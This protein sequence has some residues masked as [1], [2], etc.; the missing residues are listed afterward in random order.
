M[1]AAATAFATLA[2]LAIL[3]ASPSPHAVVHLPTTPQ[4]DEFVVEVNGKGQVVRIDSG[5]PSHDR[6]F[7][8]ITFGNALQ[9]FIRTTEGNAVA[10]RYRLRYDYDPATR[11][12]RR[13]V[14][15]LQRGG[16]DPAGGP[17]VGRPALSGGERA[18]EAHDALDGIVIDGVGGSAR[19][20]AGLFDALLEGRLGGVH[21]AGVDV[22][23]LR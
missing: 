10:G 6:A 4:H 8:S 18:E 12:I 2:T 21:D 11:R 23:E 22:A 20:L 7:D 17:V 3:G 19:D 13:N 16:V 14:A 5:T 15:I 9:V 1:R